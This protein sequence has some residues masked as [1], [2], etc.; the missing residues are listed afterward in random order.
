MEDKIAL[1]VIDTQ[2]GMF[3]IGAAPPVPNK[4]RLLNSMM[5]GSFARVVPTNEISIRETV[6]A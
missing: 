2:R 5:N 3:G 6:G 4:D 1:V